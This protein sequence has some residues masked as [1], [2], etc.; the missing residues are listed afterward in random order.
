[1]GDVRNRY[2]LA[3][4]LLLLV[5]GAAPISRSATLAV[6]NTAD[7]G[8]GTL[9]AALASAANGDTI[10]FAVATPATITLTTGELVVS[11][12]VRV[13]GPSAALTVSG[14]SASRVFRIATG[15][16][17]FVNLNIRNGLA[18]GTAG[19]NGTVMHPNGFPGGSA[20]GGGIFNNGTLVM[21]N[22]MFAGN[23]AVGGRGGDSLGIAGDGGAG[24]VGDGAAVYN[25]GTL[26][27]ANCTFSANSSTGGDGGGGFTGGNGGSADGGCIFNRG[28]LNLVSCTLCVNSVTGGNGGSGDDTGGN[29]GDGRGGG[30]LHDAGSSSTI[31]NTIIAANSAAG[32][33]AG[34]G[35]STDGISGS[36][37]GPDVF[38]SGAIASQGY[39][40]IGNTANSSGF[41]ATGDQL[42]VNPMLGPLADY[43][44]PTQTMA[45]RAGSPAIDKG[46][47]F[48]L[49]LD[50][51]GQPR[52][53][54]DPNIANATGGDGGDIG[55]YETSEL[56]VA[57]V[58]RIGNDLRLRFTSVLGTNYLVQ[59]KSDLSLTNWTTLAGSVAGNGGAAQT[60]QTNAFTQPKQFY[61]VHLQP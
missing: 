52:P 3:G 60:T 43:G 22:C 48:G 16:V 18:I 19:A 32:G 4:V 31:Q 57:S 61:R 44:G 38:S 12:N 49:G 54:D 14:N 30:L 45:L 51:R 58:D 5:V 11:N 1:M 35:F 15:T 13:F 56:R 46:K 6:T 26:T 39:N 53:Y 34:L 59:T 50:Q 17:S 24:G 23:S 8:P 41:G 25:Q 47:S 9:R 42:N 37:F 40:L 20:Q 29:G 33:S 21:T 27:V 2:T 55:A 28:T 10:N 36:N 7:S